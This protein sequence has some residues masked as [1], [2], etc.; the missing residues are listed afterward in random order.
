MKEKIETLKKYIEELEDAYDRHEGELYKN[1]IHKVF[2]IGD[3]VKKGDVIGVVAW[4]D[5]KALNLQ[6]S[7][8]YFGFDIKNGGLGFSAP[9]RRNDYVQLSQSEQLYFTSKHKITLSLTGEE[10][11]NLL[12]HIPAGCNPSKAKDILRDAL[13]I[14]KEKQNGD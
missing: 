10:I 6:E 9:C 2:C 13:N 11:E 4:I 7:D 1:S 3:W 14:I 12:Y 8:G 5:N